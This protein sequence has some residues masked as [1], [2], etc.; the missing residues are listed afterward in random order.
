ME[1]DVLQNHLGGLASTFCNPS[2]Q[3]LE[4]ATTHVDHTLRTTMAV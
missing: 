3:G 4:M 2:A 1:C